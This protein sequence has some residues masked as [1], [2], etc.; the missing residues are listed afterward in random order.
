MQKVIATLE[1]KGFRFEGNGG[2][3]L[4]ELNPKNN[5]I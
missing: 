3:I 4:V 2:R 5:N 1:N